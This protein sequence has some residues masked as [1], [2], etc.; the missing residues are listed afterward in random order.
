MNSMVSHEAQ[1]SSTKGNALG[2]VASPYTKGQFQDGGQ[3][4]AYGYKA[5]EDG[6]NS[7]GL[8]KNLQYNSHNLA[9]D[10]VSG[11]SGT[12]A[13]MNDSMQS[14]SMANYNG[15]FNRNSYGMNDQH[16]GLANTSTADFPSQNAQYNQYG[17]SSMRGGYP[18]GPRG[19]Q[20]PNRTGM[21]QPGMNMMGSNYPSNPQRFPMSG[22]SM[23][24]PGGPTPTLN[25]L[26]QNP[27]A[28]Q[29]YQ[30]AGYGY[31]TGGPKGNGDMTGG[32][33]PGGSFSQGWTGPQ[34]RPMNPYQQQQMQ[35]QGYRSQQ[36]SF[37]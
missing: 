6:V 19:S 32:N 22:P 8:A 5:R 29:R 23:Q 15:N 1:G 4:V 14:S 12:P 16:G 10:S 27:N 25:Q 33:P 13:S 21:P 7:H 26:L 36:V 24:Q 35:Q 3:N 17:P 28:A 37:T 11:Q 31:D 9:P 18:P 30:A 2:S 20:G 34:Q